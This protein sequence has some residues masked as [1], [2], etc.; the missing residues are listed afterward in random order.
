MDKFS[1]DL[2]DEIKNVIPKFG[3]HGFEH[4]LRVY[5]TCKFIGER[6]NVNMKLLLAAALLHDIARNEK[7]HAQTGAIKATGILK[8]YNLNTPEIEYIAKI[9]S[10]HSFSGKNFPENLEQRILSDADK[11]DALGAVGIYRTAMYSGEHHRSIE[12]FVE[13][14][15]N[16]L[17]KLKG[18]LFT[19][20]AKQ[21]A[22]SRISY[23]V[24]FLEQLDKEIKI[25]N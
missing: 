6:N 19:D 2:F 24:N 1:S 21:M 5:N 13:H 8:K 10:T 16:K 17:L 11:L 7:D 4:T 25:S 14:F 15:H 3:T 12:D 9:I 22:E 20:E 18:Q 23:M